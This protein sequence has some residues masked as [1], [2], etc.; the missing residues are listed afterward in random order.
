MSG[1]LLHQNLTPLPG[2]FEF[3]SIVTGTGQ[4]GHF[5][6]VASSTS[7]A[8]RNPTPGKAASE[9]ANEP[10]LIVFTQAAQASMLAQ[11][12]LPL[13]GGVDH[14]NAMVLNEAAVGMVGSLWG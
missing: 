6:G 14:L 5:K 13:M 3:Q 11:G 12:P 8:R 4:T 9:T 10:K 7:V 2:H 1:T